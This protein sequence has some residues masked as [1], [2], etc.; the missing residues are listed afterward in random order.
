MPMT[1]AQILA[2]IAPAA[3]DRWRQLFGMPLWS[4]S[5]DADDEVV[6]ALARRLYD[7]DVAV[8]FDWLT[9]YW[10]GRF[11]G[12]EGLAS[13]PVADAVRMLASYLHGERAAAG[14]V[15]S[16]LVDGSIPAAINRLWD[17]YRESRVGSDAAFV[18]HAECSADGTYLWS[19]ERR[20][21]PGGALCWVGLNPGPGDRDAGSRPALRRVASWARR[22]GC[23]A[24]VVVNL[25]SL[26]S[27]DP[28]TLQAVD[29]D[30]VGD[31]T[32]DA[33]RAASRDAVITLAAWG[34][35]KMV[36]QRSPEVLALLDNPMCVGVNKNGEPRH[37]LYV[38]AATALVEYRP[39][40][41]TARIHSRAIA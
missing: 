39:S 41:Q 2:A 3:D 20:W 24:V 13:A 5:D 12:G 27:A 31:R 32:N 10:P 37:P 16:G 29:D 14:A 1:D 21:A 34:A 25:F 30:V 22:E 28:R 9:W 23:A 18:D 11:P 26:R 35:S 17:W 36:R 38:P 40:E 15:R 33:I 19:Y 8:S 4:T 6:D 7:L